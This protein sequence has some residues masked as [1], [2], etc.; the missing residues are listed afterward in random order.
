MADSENPGTW[1]EDHGD[2]LY[3]F[4][5]S[6]LQNEELA[7][8]MLQETLLAAWKGREHFK[9]NA[10]IR[11]WLVSIL[12]HKIID[13][14]RLEIRNRDLA[15]NV[16]HDPTSVYFNA[17]GSWSEVPHAWKDNPEALCRS[18]EFRSV[19]ETC[20]SK[21]PV[22]QRLVF[23]MRD[24]VGEDTETV[25][26]ACDITPTHLHVLLHRARLGL[27]HCLEQNWFARGVK[28]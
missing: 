20:A 15:R 24:I 17:D 23:H 22:Q 19:L 6:R 12:K 4:A 1:L 25:C 14:I 21:L 9:G 18:Q 3:R 5:M 2:Y 8:D 26:K 13:H 11:T 16:E 28:R 10:S 7:E 27:R